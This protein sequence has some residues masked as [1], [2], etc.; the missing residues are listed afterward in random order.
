MRPL[1]FAECVGDTAIGQVEC[2]DTAL[3]MKPVCFCSLPVDPELLA[4]TS[5]THGR[6]R[7]LP[8]S[9]GFLALLVAHCFH[10]EI[11]ARFKV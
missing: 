9:F 3:E 2:T 7:F 8:T 4:K 5:Q 10:Q 1:P 11:S 6:L